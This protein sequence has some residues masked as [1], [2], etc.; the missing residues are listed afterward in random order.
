M[1]IEWPG[2][3]VAPAPVADTTSTPGSAL[4]IASTCAANQP[5]LW[6]SALW[7][8][9]RV[10][11][12]ALAVPVGVDS[13]GRIKPELDAKMMAVPRRITSTAP[14]NS[15]RRDSQVRRAADGSNWDHTSSLTNDACLIWSM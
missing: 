13:C 10:A 1:V 3:I 14:L 8:N 2:R 15:M 6:I 7:S 9:S 4:L 5:S 12:S 11:E